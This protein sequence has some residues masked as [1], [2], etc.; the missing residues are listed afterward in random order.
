[1]A[2]LIV[3]LFISS[4]ES[5]GFVDRTIEKT[6]DAVENAGPNDWYTLAISAEKCFNK[7]VNLNEASKWLN[8]SL[9]IEETPFN[10]EL[11][12]D[13]CAEN[14]LPDKALEYYVRT[15]NTLKA[16]DGK[17]EVS[18]IQKKI[19]EIIKI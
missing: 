17:A 18:H 3:I 11:K 14:L 10:L 5:F 15:M 6:R 19:S 1:M 13:F 4:S 7:K 12:G 8:Q 16:R 2:T 9:E